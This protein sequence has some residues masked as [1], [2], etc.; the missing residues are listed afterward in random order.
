MF[1]CFPEKRKWYFWN[2]IMR[3]YTI[4]ISGWTSH[5]NGTQY[6]S[7]SSGVPGPTWEQGP[8]YTRTAG[9]QKGRGMS[10]YQWHPFSCCTPE[11][12]FQKMKN[13]RTH[14]AQTPF[15]QAWPLRVLVFS[16]IYSPRIITPDSCASQFDAVSTLDASGT[17]PHNKTQ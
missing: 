2:D 4:L 6:Y 7:G 12:C 16:L 5:L 9:G 1:L 14:I 13:M 15:F 10:V 11:S 3:I 8:I 17:S